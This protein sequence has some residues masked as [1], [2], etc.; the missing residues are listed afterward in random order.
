MKLVGCTDAKTYASLCSVCSYTTTGDDCPHCDKVK[1]Y[2]GEP[3][4]DYK[5][6]GCQDGKE[7]FMCKDC[8]C[9][10]GGERC[11]IVHDCFV[12]MAVGHHTLRKSL[13]E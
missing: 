1:L 11:I 2:G 8:L 12:H 3:N 13:R 10:P 7:F 5:L 9:V 4:P 6:V